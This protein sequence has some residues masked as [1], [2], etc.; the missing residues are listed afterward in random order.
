[1]PTRIDVAN[2]SLEAHG[3][4]MSNPRAREGLSERGRVA[5][6][7]LVLP[8]RTWG[9]DSSHTVF[10]PSSFLMR[11]S[12][13]ARAPYVMESVVAESPPRRIVRMYKNTGLIRIT[14]ISRP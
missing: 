13:S 8:Y 1:M 2:I 9:R 14:I 3:V 12:K 5:P 7:A 4:H 6:M 11:D 10:P